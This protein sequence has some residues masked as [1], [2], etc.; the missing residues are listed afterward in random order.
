MISLIDIALNL[1]NRIFKCP[2]SIRIGRTLIFYI[3]TLE[4]FMTLFPL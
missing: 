4:I 1:E 2:F 3:F